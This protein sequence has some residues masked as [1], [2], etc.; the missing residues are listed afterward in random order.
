MGKID[1]ATVAPRL[2]GKRRIEP[3]PKGALVYDF[4]VTTDRPDDP[5]AAVAEVTFRAGP[6]SL[7]V[8]LIRGEEAVGTFVPGRIRTWAGTPYL[9]NIEGGRSAS[10]VIDA[11]GIPRSFVVPAP[12][13]SAYR[14]GPAGEARHAWLLTGTTVERTQAVMGGTLGVLIER[15][16][17]GIAIHASSSAALPSR[18]ALDRLAAER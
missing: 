6:A 9:D 11:L 4:D 7:K 15:S 5:S 10:D 1:I 13:L 17:R 8:S 3:G 16:P 18:S 14:L 2:A 12:P